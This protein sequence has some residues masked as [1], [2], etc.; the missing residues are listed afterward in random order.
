MD[1]YN[2]Y[3]PDELGY[4]REGRQDGAQSQAA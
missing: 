1:E 3:G 4:V 2:G